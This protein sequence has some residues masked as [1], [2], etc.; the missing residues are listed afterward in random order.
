MPTTKIS[1]METNA[2]TENWSEVMKRKSNRANR[3]SSPNLRIFLTGLAV[4]AFRFAAPL[5][6]KK[7]NGPC[8]PFKTIYDS[9]PNH[10]MRL[11]LELNTVFNL[12]ARMS[13]WPYVS[14]KIAVHADDYCSF[15][16]S[17]LWTA[18]EFQH[19]NLVYIAYPSNWS[20]CVEFIG[21]KRKAR[22]KLQ[23]TT[24]ICEFFRPKFLSIV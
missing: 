14:F 9:R 4:T 6:P 15:L 16:S 8:F 21:Y 11:N 23:C 17:S 7:K 13:S 1:L 3:E 5:I 2:T 19:N 20:C 24:R 18:S 22:T 12:S 10:L